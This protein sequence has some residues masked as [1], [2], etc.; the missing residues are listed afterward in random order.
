[1]PVIADIFKLIFA[2]LLATAVL[3]LIITRFPLYKYIWPEYPLHHFFVILTMYLTGSWGYKTVDSLRKTCGKETKAMT[4][5]LYVF[6][7]LAVYSVL[8]FLVYLGMESMIGSSDLVIVLLGL[9][10]IPGPA[11]ILIALFVIIY[12]VVIAFFLRGRFWIFL[13]TMCVLMTAHFLFFYILMEI[14][15]VV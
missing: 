1:M 11:S 8:G 13:V 2:I 5:S 10:M 15:A 6:G 3:L 7:F 9:V 14:A 4:V 12:T